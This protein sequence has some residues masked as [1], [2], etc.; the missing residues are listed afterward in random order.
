LKVADDLDL[1]E[2][3]AAR[4]FLEVQDETDSSGRSAV[5]NSIVRFH[6]RRKHLLDCLCILFRLSVDEEAQE[7][8]K[9]YVQSII[10]QITRN[11]AGSPT[12]IQR[13]L[14]S[15]K[16]IKTWLQRLA[17]RLNGVSVIDQGQ[18][19]DILE[20][21]EYQRVSLVKQHESLGV[22]AFHFGK[23]K[24]AEVK[25]FE[26]V[27]GILKQADKYDNLLRKFVLYLPHADDR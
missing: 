7:D 16:D 27:L 21:I 12:Y 18:Q 15:M 25:D 13:C 19:Q 14:T 24:G 4:I 3:D 9:S 11:Q 5:T 6:Q 10:G 1:D 8:I 17:E 20:S 26:L 23:E 2:L 22:I